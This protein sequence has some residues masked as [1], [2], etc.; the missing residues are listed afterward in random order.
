[1][2]GS[3]VLVLTQKKR[4]KK[5][6]IVS[7][8]ATYLYWH[9][10]TFVNI[11]IFCLYIT[12]AWTSFLLVYGECWTHCMIGKISAD[13][14]L[15]YFSYFSQRIGFG[16]SCKLETIC[17]LQFAWNV[18]F[19]FIEKKKK[20]IIGLSSAEFARKLVLKKHVQKEWKVHWIITK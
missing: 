19:Y 20:Y 7:Y 13:D 15:K 8:T 5:K 2:T 14:V 16:N 18:K 9:L 3:A 11:I 17:I 6:A 12:Y 10:L 1:M 4:N